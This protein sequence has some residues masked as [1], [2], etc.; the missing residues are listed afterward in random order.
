MADRVVLY[1]EDVCLSVCLFVCLFVMV[2]LFN[3]LMSIGV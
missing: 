2:R 3:G 1:E